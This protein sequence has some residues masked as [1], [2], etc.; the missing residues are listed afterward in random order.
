MDHSVAQMYACNIF[1]ANFLEDWEESKDRLWRDTHPHS[2]KQYGKE[3][4]KLARN[5][6]N[7][8]YESYA[9]FRETPCPHTIKTPYYGSTAKTAD[10]ISVAEM[11]YTAALE[12]RAHAQAERVLELEASVDG[13]TFLT[14]ATEY[15]ASAVTVGGNNKDLKELITMMN[16]LTASVTAQAET[17]AEL[18]VKTHSGSDGGRKNIKM[19]K[20]RPGLHVCAHCKK[21]VYHKDG[22]CLE[23]AANGAKRYTGW[24]RILE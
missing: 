21:E 18:S 4:C 11:E 6:S 16:Q 19:K 3:R 9:A 22:N 24:T 5:K 17:L 2:M 15:T 14:K 23:L 10:G 20:A 13:Q 7:K 1:E 8:S 12:E